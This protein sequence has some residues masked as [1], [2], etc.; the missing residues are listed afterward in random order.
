MPPAIETL[1]STK[2]FSDTALVIFGIVAVGCVVILVAVVIW[3]AKTRDSRKANSSGYVV[4]KKSLSDA[5]S[6]PDFWIDQN[7]SH[8]VKGNLR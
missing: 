4:G 1:P 5:K 7:R 6:P 2:F 8:H 3:R